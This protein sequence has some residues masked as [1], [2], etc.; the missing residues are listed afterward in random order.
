MNFRGSEDT[1]GMS[2][3]NLGHAQHMA[4]DLWLWPTDQLANE[5]SSGQQIQCIPTAFRVQ[6]EMQH[7][8]RDKG[9][10]L[11]LDAMP[12]GL[13]IVCVDLHYSACSAIS[14]W[15]CAQVNQ[16][17]SANGYSSPHRHPQLVLPEVATR[18]GHVLSA[19]RVKCRL[20]VQFLVFATN[21]ERRHWWWV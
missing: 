21:R 17:R 16:L 1:K 10:R 13:L 11:L 4:H 6:M 2:N 15:K 18:H 19:G 8:Q 9:R 12:F 7:Q 5:Q 14:Q 20:W 3:C